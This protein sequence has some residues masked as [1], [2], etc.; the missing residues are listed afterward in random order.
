MECNLE[1]DDRNCLCKRKLFYSVLYFVMMQNL[2][3]KYVETLCSIVISKV[4]QQLSV[5][6]WGS[7]ITV[8]AHWAAGQHSDQSILHWGMIHTTFIL[9][10]LIAW[11]NCGLK[12]NSSHCFS[13]VYFF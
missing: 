13:L 5:H 8:V 4:L 3:G 2:K 6:P 9:L 10:A 7:H 1:Q 11:Q 12:H